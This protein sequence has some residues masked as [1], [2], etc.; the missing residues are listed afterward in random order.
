MTTMVKTGQL[1]QL[2]SVNLFN[3]H[4][5]NLVSLEDFDLSEELTHFIYYSLRVT[6][7]G[8]FVGYRVGSQDFP[9]DVD[10]TV[11]VE[12]YKKYNVNNIPVDFADHLVQDGLAEKIKP[13]E[14]DL[15]SDVIKPKS[16]T[17]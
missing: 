3:T 10:K 11:L 15:I 8:K 1:F 2:K 13:T 17:N 5:F 16:K 14:F 7:N 12:A 4:E 6:I 9:T